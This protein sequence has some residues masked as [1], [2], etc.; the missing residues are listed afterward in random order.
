MA[1]LAQFIYKCRKQPDMY[2]KI[3]AAIALCLT[4]ISQTFADKKGRSRR[5]DGNPSKMTV[6]QVWQLPNELREIS[7]NVFI[8]QNRLACIQDNDGAIFIYNLE[9]KNIDRTIRF[10]DPGDYEA[11]AYTGND[12]FVLRSDGLLL[13]I[14]A[15]KNTRPKVNKYKLPFTKA[16]DLESLHFDKVNNRLLIISKEQDLGS[17]AGKGI[18]SFDLRTKKFNSTPT[19]QVLYKGGIIKPSDLAVNIHTKEVYIL[20][21]PASRLLIVAASGEVTS[22][23]Q[24]NRKT[25]VQPEGIC[26]SPAGELFI[27]SEGGK[28]GN[29]VLAKVEL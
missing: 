29:G 11:I 7:G 9:T 14:D 5:H 22:T 1:L 17:N 3:L 25:F 26:F 20:D 8:D 2:I 27:S 4:C 19:G 23:L 21:G 10:G 12:Y 24:L 28:H 18:Y 6:V 16:N 13:E 15:T